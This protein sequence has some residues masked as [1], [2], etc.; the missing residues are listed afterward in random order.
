LLQKLDEVAMKEYQYGAGDEEK[1]AVEVPTEEATPR[2]A[3]KSRK[4]K[5]TRKE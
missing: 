5:P 3:R 2:A 1:E 4:D